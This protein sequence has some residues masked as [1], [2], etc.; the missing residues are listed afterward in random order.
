MNFEFV[1]TLVI[2]NDIFYNEML[3]LNLLSKK[4]SLSNS[5]KIRN[6]III[7]LPFLWKYTI[8]LGIFLLLLTITWFVFRELK[9]FSFKN[10]RVLEALDKNDFRKMLFLHEPVDVGFNDNYLYMKTDGYEGKVN[11][12]YIVS[13]DFSDKWFIVR[14]SGFPCFY[15]NIIE[16]KKYDAYYRLLALANEHM[17]DKINIKNN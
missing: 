8:S 14:C 11:W 17:N 5:K 3:P 13:Y 6:A 15:F 2:N 7:I 1:H 12:K 9:L 4:Y 10:K 16:L